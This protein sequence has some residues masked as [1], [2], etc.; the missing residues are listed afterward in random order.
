M[1]M[2][3]PNKILTHLNQTLA[4]WRGKRPSEQQAYGGSMWRG[5]SVKVWCD[6][7]AVVAIINQNTIKDFASMHL[8]RCLAFITAK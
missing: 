1:V 3:L 4:E 7:E 8:M 2:R 5:Q 6:N